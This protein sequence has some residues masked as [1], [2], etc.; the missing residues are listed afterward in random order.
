MTDD[1]LHCIDILV[2]GRFLREEKDISL[3]F[4]GS[5]NQ[6]IIDLPRTL[7]SDRIVLWDQLRR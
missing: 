2:D 5:R 6:R 1:L 7:S 4:R 3:Q